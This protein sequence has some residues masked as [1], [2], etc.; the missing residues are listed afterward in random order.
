MSFKQKTSKPQLPQPAQNPARIPVGFM[1][2]VCAAHHVCVKR[3]GLAWKSLRTSYPWGSGGVLVRRADGVI[4]QG[5][6]PQR[7]HVGRN[8]KLASGSELTG[9]HLCAQD[10]SLGARRRIQS[11]QHRGIFITTSLIIA[12]PMHLFVTTS[13][14]RNQVSFR[15]VTQATSGLDV[16]DLQVPTSPAELARP[17]IA[18]QNLSS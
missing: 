13:T 6:D 18:A 3:R 4:A 14:K 1:H 16:M 10:A 7:H 15:I 5:C 2:D 17:S 12:E 11:Q 8:I 9:S